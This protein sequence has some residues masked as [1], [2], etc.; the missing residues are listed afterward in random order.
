[1]VMETELSDAQVEAMLVDW[2][3]WARPEQLAPDGAWRTW[4]IK[5][6]RGWGKTRVGAE[7][8]RRQLETMP[9]CRVAIVARTYS[10]ARDTCIEGEGGLLSCLPSDVRA[11]VKWNR[12]IGEGELPNGSSWKIFTAEKPDSLRGPQFHVLWADEM[13]AWPKNRAAWSQVP[14]IVRLPWRDDPTKAGRVLVTTTPRPVREIR[15]LIRDPG[16]QVTSGSSFDN[17][18]NLN[19]ATRAE[20]EKLKN[21]RL[22]RQELFGEVLDDTPGALWTR[23]TVVRQRKQ[24]PPEGD[25]S[26]I[27]VAVDPAVT[28][29]ENSDETGIIVAARGEGRK[30]CERYVLSDRSIRGS[31]AQWARA[32]VAAYREFGASAIV[33]ET[34]QGGDMCR[35]T[36]LAVDGSLPII[37]VRASKG[38]R[39]RAEPIAA[40]YEQGS[41]WHVG[42]G[43]ETLEDQLCTWTDDADWSPDRLDALV[44]AMTALGQSAASE[45]RAKPPKH[46]PTGLAAVDL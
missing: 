11:G 3:V 38:K 22:G 29:G 36:L 19:A 14:F 13:A 8:V 17:W 26:R 1:M 35:D 12:S 2:S 40:A 37:D 27:I 46:R 41:V 10:D 21:T 31:P 28:S 6:G 5:S 43:L 44:W 7:W 32:A 45:I 34:N 9:G 16:T 30:H 25:L 15:D 23:A 24:R 39:A 42:D 33:I 18:Q 20:L 4:L